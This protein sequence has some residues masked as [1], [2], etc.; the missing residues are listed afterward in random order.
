MLRPAAKELKD[1]GGEAEVTRF[2]H[3]GEEKAEG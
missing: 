3:L 1:L 2:V